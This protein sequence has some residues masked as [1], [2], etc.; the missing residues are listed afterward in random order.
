MPHAGGIR[1]F[2]F[3]VDDFLRQVETL[4]HD[5]HVGLNDRFTK[6]TK[7]FLILLLNHIAELFFTDVIILQEGRNTE[8]STQEGV[9]LHSQLQVLSGG[10]LFGNVKTWKNE[11][12]DVVVLDVLS[13]SLGNPLPSRLGRIT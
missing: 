2:N 12:S 6:A 7:L 4:G 10:R 3:T 8:E 5:L 1:I 9:P 13:M 11:N